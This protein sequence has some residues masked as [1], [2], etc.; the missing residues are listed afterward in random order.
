MVNIKEYWQITGI[1]SVLTW[2]YGPSLYVPGGCFTKVSRALQDIL[3]K[4]VY[5]RNRTFDEN[6]KLKLC[7]WAQSYALGT[8]T[9]F[10][11]KILTI[12]VISGIVY[13]REII[14]E[15]SRNLS[16][17]TPWYWWCTQ[18]NKEQQ[19]YEHV[20]WDTVRYRYNVVK[21]LHNPHTRHSIA[22]PWGRGME[23]L[24]WI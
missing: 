9:K 13:F 5:Y 23:W 14:L 11:L 24:L 4:F 2:T 8:R 16:E 22:R 1:P 12:N 18:Q 7:T 21:F 15:S 10:Q 17:T 6:F 3:S 20:L 19:N